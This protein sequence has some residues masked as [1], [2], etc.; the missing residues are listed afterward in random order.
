MDLKPLHQRAANQH[1]LITRFQAAELGISKSQW[2]RL[3]NRGL[4]LPIY[5]NV[6]AIFGF[7][8]TRHQSILAAV[9]SG[10][11][12]GIASHRTAAA[13]WGIWTPKEGE[14]I[15]IIKLGR[16]RMTPVVGVHFHHPRDHEDI[17][18]IK[19]EKI[20]TTSAARTLLDFAAVEPYKL[21]LATEKMLINAD[22]SR[23]RLIA[24]VA[25]HSERGRSGIGPMRDLLATWPYASKPADSVLELEMQR[26]LGRHE[27]PKFETQIPIGPFRADLGWPEWKVASETDGW[28]KYERREDFERLAERDIYFQKQGWLIAHFTWRD[29]KGRSRYVV[30]T[31]RDLL[32]S[33]GYTGF[34][35]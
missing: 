9:L 17:A 14:P 22:I 16:K 25:R 18:P 13:L 30:Q 26:L 2:H 10:D 19:R 33:R 31:L 28:G 32:R 21:P 4:L 7:P 27:F 1:G 20:R 29:I 5:P 35:F 24:A 8:P 23:D 6:S 3:N 34:G 12:L 15:D 11:G